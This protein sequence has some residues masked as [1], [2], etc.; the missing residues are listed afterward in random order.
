M[1]Q[2][3]GELRVEPI[4]QLAGVS[5]A[6]YYRSLQQQEPKQEEMMVRAAIQQ[7]VL[8]HKRRYGS[9]RVTRELQN[10]GLAVNHKRV[11]RLMREDNLLAL[12]Q[13]PFRVTTE[14]RHHL[15]VYLNLAARMELT[16]INQVWVADITYLRLAEEF[17]YLAVVLDRFSRRVVGWALGRNLTT[18]LTADALQAAIALRHPPP[19]L[20]HHSDRGVQYASEEYI[21]LLTAQG[22]LPSMSRPANPYDNA[23]CESFMKTLKSEEIYCQQYRDL[24]DL[25][26]NIE[27]FIDGYYNRVR[28]HSALGYRTPI[29]FEAAQP[30][31]PPAAGTA[32]ATVSFPRHGE[33]YRS[34]G[35]SGEPAAAGSPA[36]RLDESP[37]DYSSVSCSPAELTSAS[38]S[39]QDLVATPDHESR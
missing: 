26:H 1:T 34:D 24:E 18:R 8:E 20:V 30:V 2:E 7:I 17:V 38:P 33:I 16:G 23:F 13:R 29:A 25:R 15:P 12:R 36:H 4:C 37:D 6:G 39:D 14:A 19:G 35:S 9:P 3:Q 21:A 28:L 32:A 10:R 11:E 22:M 5:R 31:A 27:A